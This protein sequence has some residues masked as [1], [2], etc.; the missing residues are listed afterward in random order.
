[1]PPKLTIPDVLDLS[2]GEIL[3]ASIV[4]EQSCADHHVQRM[5]DETAR[6]RNETT[7]YHCPLCLDPLTI[8]GAKNRQYHFMHPEAPEALCP[9]R[10]NHTMTMEEI[11]AC[12]YDGAKE[13]DAHH[14]LKNWIEQ[15]LRAD[16]NFD[17]SSIHREK[18]ISGI[19]DTKSWKE[20][21]QPDVQARSK[22]Q[23]FV[24]EIQLS[25]TF[26][27]VVAGRREFYLKNGACL[28]WIFDQSMINSEI[29]RFMER[30]IFFNNNRN[31][32]FITKE[33]VNN[34]IK[35]GELRLMCRYEQLTLVEFETK[36]QIV[37]QEVGLSEL[38]I[39]LE[40]QRIFFYD[41]DYIWKQL[42]DEIEE[43]LGASETPFDEKFDPDP[44][45][46]TN[47][48]Y[49]E[50]RAFAENILFDLNPDP[51]EINT[52][53]NF[54]KYWKKL[55]YHKSSER[56]HKVI[57]NY[58]V[59]EFNKQIGVIQSDFSVEIRTV[60]CALISLK[61]GVI[62]GSKLA[63]LRAL[64]NLIFSSYLKYYRLFAFGVVAFGRED[65]L[66]IHVSETTCNRHAQNY[67]FHKGEPKYMQSRDL[68]EFA[69]FLFPEF[70]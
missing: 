3:A 33:S 64:E 50:E 67:K 46:I 49:L 70:R 38:T 41:Y 18:R 65:E 25:T 12:K 21:R 15:S 16:P 11:N 1:M 29:M 56:A 37:E 69:K 32:F 4:I 24:F 42:D 27:S 20:W 31:L 6:L 48:Y 36:S 34:S 19:K 68:D 17:P 59:P 51:P 44:T 52:Q 28:I 5:K 60:I 2:S 63:N 58:Y 54:L 35:H 22:G 9:Y 45:D 53:Q 55:C 40:A 13:S 8:R 43:L 14:R 7:R 23:L 61:E 66:K 62:F 10:S 57:W 26:L 47:K 39:D 30:D